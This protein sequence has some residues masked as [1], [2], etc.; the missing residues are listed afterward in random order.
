MKFEDL[1]LMKHVNLFEQFTNEKNSSTEKKLKKEKA[2]L[3]ALI[4]KA[5]DEIDAD[6]DGPKSV[7]IRQRITRLN[8]DLEKIENEDNR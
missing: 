4:S 7:Q 8:T 5:W 3:E 1:K 2:N 6:G